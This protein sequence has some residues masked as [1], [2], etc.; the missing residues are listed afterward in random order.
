MTVKSSERRSVAVFISMLAVSS[1]TMLL[2]FWKFPLATAG[3]TFAVL[4]VLGILAVLSRSI[5]VEQP[6]LDLD[7]GKQRLY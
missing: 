5:E 7:Q 6:D 1:A 3:V 2:L 4:T